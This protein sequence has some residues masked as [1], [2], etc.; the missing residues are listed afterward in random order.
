MPKGAY[1]RQGMS[2]LESSEIDL[3]TGC[4]NWLRHTVDGYG[5]KRFR[6]RDWKMHRISAVLFLGF[7]PRS[8]LQVLHR[9]DN[10]RCF[11]PKHLFIGTNDD[12]V[13]DKVSKGRQGDTHPRLATHCK[14]GHEYTPDNIYIGPNVEYRR[15]R[16]CM[17]VTRRK[18][19]LR[20]VKR[21][22]EKGA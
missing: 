19:Y 4:W 2:L 22:A 18:K 5:I 7:D 21:A 17:R 12:N 14:Q 9:C 16:Q 1:F 13:K 20:A 10:R 3:Q 11:N 15:C 6:G 8:G